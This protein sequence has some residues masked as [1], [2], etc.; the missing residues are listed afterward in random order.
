MYAKGRNAKDHSKTFFKGATEFVQV[1]TDTSMR[2]SLAKD[3]G[4]IKKILDDSRV[5][6]NYN[7]QIKRSQEED[8]INAGIAER[9]G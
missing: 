4:I 8:M 9:S 6:K 5:V 2:N 1:Q 3:D 7:V